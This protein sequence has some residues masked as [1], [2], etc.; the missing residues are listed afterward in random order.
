MVNEL[1]NNKVAITQTPPASGIS[2]VS[3]LLGLL[4]SA[5]AGEFR[6]DNPL[7]RPGKIY[8]CPFK[9]CTTS[10]LFRKAELTG[11]KTS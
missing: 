2:L 1:I 9:K 4:P 6:T 10:C 8:W 11:K 5:L 7:N 3:I